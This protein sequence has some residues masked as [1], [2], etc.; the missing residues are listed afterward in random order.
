MAHLRELQTLTGHEVCAQRNGQSQRESP[1]TP[2]HVCCAGARVV[3]RLV[4]QRQH[5]GQLRRRPHS[6]P[7]GAE[8]LRRRR[9]RAP[10]LGVCGHAGGA[11]Q[12]NRALRRLVRSL[13]ALART[14]LS[15][16]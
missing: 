6:A 15:C 5:A 2:L 9:G 3:R 10:N 8:R 1:E 11:A 7:V 16:H 12:Q 14:A 13:H 4:A